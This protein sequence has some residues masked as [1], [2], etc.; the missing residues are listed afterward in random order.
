MD[1]VANLTE[2]TAYDSE[3][4]LE[5]R[6]TFVNLVKE[7]IVAQFFLLRHGVCI[8]IFEN[9]TI[10]SNPGS[11]PINDKHLTKKAKISEFIYTRCLENRQV[12]KAS[13]PQ[14]NKCAYN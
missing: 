3:K 5:N 2:N 8:Y 7:C 12:K 13:Q 4:D 14:S 11:F 9:I 6:L 1:F 10:F